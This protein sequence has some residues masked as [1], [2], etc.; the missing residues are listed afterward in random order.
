MKKQFMVLELPQE[1]EPFLDLYLNEAQIFNDYSAA[2]DAFNH[3]AQQIEGR[4]A[5]KQPRGEKALLSE[6]KYKNVE[7]WVINR[8]ES[9]NHIPYVPSVDRTR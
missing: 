3:A 9:D 8:P 2:F 5:E 4:I 7:L 1:A 6:G